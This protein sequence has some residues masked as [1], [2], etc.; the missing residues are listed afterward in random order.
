MLLFKKKYLPAIRSGAKSQTIRLWSCRRMRTG[1]RSYI[2]GAG[3][4]HV[5]AVEP[6]ALDQLTDADAL[7]DGFHSA[8]E[9]RSE[10]ETLYAEQLAAGWQAYRVRFELAPSD[11]RPNV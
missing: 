2:P 3:H 10:L 1:Q 6:V 7:P 8:A 5:T 4:I 11:W 9:L